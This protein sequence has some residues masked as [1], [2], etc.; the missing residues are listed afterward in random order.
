MWLTASSSGIDQFGL[1]PLEIGVRLTAWQLP[2]L[3]S[4]EPQVGNAALV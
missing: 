2:P 4:Q 3:A 1:R